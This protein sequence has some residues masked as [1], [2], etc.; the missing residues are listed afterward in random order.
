MID[1]EHLALPAVVIAHADH[2]RPLM[3]DVADHLVPAIWQAGLEVDLSDHLF[4]VFEVLDEK[5]DHQKGAENSTHTD[6]DS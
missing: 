2:L 1:H 3:V 5:P 6:T 4:L